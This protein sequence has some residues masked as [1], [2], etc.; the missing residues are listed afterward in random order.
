MTQATK[1]HPKAP[2]SVLTF[3]APDGV[4]QPQL[5][6][7]LAHLFNHLS[8]L[9]GQLVRGRKAQTLEKERGEMGTRA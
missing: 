3:V 7:K 5:R 6:V 4:G 1:L 8:R 2:K 9:E